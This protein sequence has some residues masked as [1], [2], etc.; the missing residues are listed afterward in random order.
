VALGE[1]PRLEEALRR[2][3]FHGEVHVAALLAEVRPHQRPEHDEA[4]R[5]EAFG[6]P[7]GQVRQS[8][9]DAAPLLLVGRDAPSVPRHQRTRRRPCSLAILHVPMLRGPGEATQVV[10][11]L[12]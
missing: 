8:H 12:V 3:A 2:D 6:E 9:Q 5:S 7:T 10:G 4:R 1:R 11:R